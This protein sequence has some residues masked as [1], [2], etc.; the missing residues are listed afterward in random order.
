MGTLVPRIEWEWGELCIKVGSRIGID[1]GQM[2][3]IIWH[4]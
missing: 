2:W 4:L 3:M 1:Q